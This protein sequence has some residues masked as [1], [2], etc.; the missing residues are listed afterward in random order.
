MPLLT[1]SG[2]TAAFG[3]ASCCALP[4]FLAGLGLGSAWLAGIAIYAFYHR[5]A[6]LPVALVGLAGGA[7]LLWKHRT[8]P[9]PVA[10]GLAGLM[11]SVGAVLLYCGIAY[12]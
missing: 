12:V 6:F 8:T 11:L 9:K 7:V 2:I 4:F 1:L 5:T 3:L 10:I